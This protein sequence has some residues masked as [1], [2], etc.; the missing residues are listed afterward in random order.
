MNGVA[1]IFS[2]GSN[3]AGTRVVCTPQVIVPLGASALAGALA[4]MT[5][6]V[7]AANRVTS[8]ITIVSLSLEPQLFV[9]RRVWIA[10][11]QAE[12]RLL[13]PGPHTGQDGRLPERRKHHLLMNQLLDAVQC[14]LAPFAVELGAL[15]AK[16][17]VDV[18]VASVNVHA[19]RGHEGFDAG[20]GVAEH[21]AVGVHEVLEF[22][23]GEGLHERGPLERPDLHAE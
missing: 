16:E 18:G 20:G 23:L 11:D 7:R 19:A 5:S 4:T 15:L 10:A 1:W 3:Q 21:R 14:H 17:P 2:A 22:L 9:R 12:P 13:N 6:S 8:R